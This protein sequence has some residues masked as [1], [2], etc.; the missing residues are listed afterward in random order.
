MSS[1]RRETLGWQAF[2]L[3]LHTHTHT[4]APSPCTL[5]IFVRG[6][7]GRTLLVRVRRQDSAVEV[8]QEILRRQRIGGA[9]PRL[10]YA[11]KQLLDGVCLEEYGVRE[12]STLH[13]VLGLRGGAGEAEV[14]LVN[15]NV[16]SMR[17]HADAILRTRADL[18]ALQEVRLT[19]AA[20]RAV[21]SKAREMGWDCL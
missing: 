11:G 3:L 4:G 18:L 13:L 9:G 12:G 16:T 5:Q 20:Q 17:A 1:E 19:E 21:R 2:D 7:D 14:H 8:K 6:L 10:I 15:A